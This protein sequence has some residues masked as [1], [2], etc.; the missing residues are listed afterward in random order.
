MEDDPLDDMYDPDAGE[1]ED[2]GDLHED[3]EG[4]HIVSNKGEANLAASR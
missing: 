2:S 1:N 3:Y 4:G